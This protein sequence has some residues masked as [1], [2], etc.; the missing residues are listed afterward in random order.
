MKKAIF[1]LLMVLSITHFAYAHCGMCGVGD[2]DHAHNQ[3]PEMLGEAV[4]ED[5]DATEEV[6]DQV[7]DWDEDADAMTEEGTNEMA[8]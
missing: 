4:D 3:A 7:A 5:W 2:E 8:E 1:A 6:T